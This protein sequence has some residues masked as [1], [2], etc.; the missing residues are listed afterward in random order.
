[1]KEHISIIFTKFL[2]EKSLQKGERLKDSEVVSFLKSK[3]VTDKEATQMIRDFLV[4]DFLSICEIVEDNQK[5]YSVKPAL[6]FSYQDH[7]E[8]KLALKNSRE[9]K[10]WAIWSIL[11][12][13]FFAFLQVLVNFDQPKIFLQSIFRIFSKIC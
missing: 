1:M 4:N 5:L 2:F 13:A 7:L 3:G 10:C 9:A 12:G 8:Y 6:I 11:I